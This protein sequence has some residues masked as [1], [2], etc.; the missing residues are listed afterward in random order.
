[1][2]QPI[3]LKAEHIMDI[4]AVCPE[5]ERIFVG[6]NDFGLLRAICITGG[7]FHGEK[8]NGRIVPGGADWN[9]GYGG[10]SP[11]TFTSVNVFA[12]Y[13]LQ[14]D[15]GIY[16]AIENSGKRDKTKSQPLIVT[17]P[18]FFAPRGKYEWLNYGVY[19]GSLNGCIRDGIKGVDIVIYKMF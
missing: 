3:E 18:R 11:E 7:E 4:H 15:D 13:L 12:K 10:E 8:L 16:I 6:Q 9:T 17:T 1:M 19:V 2:S 5:K 14:T